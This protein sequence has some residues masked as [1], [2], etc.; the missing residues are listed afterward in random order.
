M[1]L[2]DRDYS[3]SS[4]AAGG[5]RPPR[6]GGW[7]SRSPIGGLTRLSANSVLIIVCCALFVLD[8][9]LP[10]TPVQLSEWR[11]TPGQEQAWQDLQRAHGVVTTRALAPDAQGVGRWI[12]WAGNI[13]PAVSAWIDPIAEADY[14]M[15]SPLRGWLQFTTAQAIVSF[16]P[17]GTMQGL[18]FWRF[19]GYGFLHVGLA[20]LLFNMVGLWVFGGIVEERFGRRRYFA[21]FAVSVIAGALLFLV[22]NAFGIALG[23]GTAAGLSI[24]GLLS[25]DPYTPLVGASAG[26]YGIIL[27]AAWLA[28]DEEVLLFFVLPMRIR[29]LALVLLA[30]AVY[31]LLSSGRNAGGEAAHLGGAVAGWWVARRPHLLDD[32]F[33][34]FGRR[35]SPRSTRPL[36][37]DEREIDRILDKV[38]DKGLGSLSPRERDALR[39]ASR[40]GRGAD[41]RG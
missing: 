12:V 25:S 16:A 17:D 5:P 27:A 23:G 22:L 14:L 9:V 41:G 33:D 8:L 15:V 40:S 1:G 2:A 21:I 19:I 35:V 24:P 18:Q 20:H 29:T 7:I 11:V 13:P 26:V 38:R 31:A 6:R 10:E 32:F 28:P 39:S 36:P 3:R 37:V 4:R 30:L 34:L